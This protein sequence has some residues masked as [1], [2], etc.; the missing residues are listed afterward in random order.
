[1]SWR[2][3][4]K[5]HGQIYGLVNNIRNLY[6]IQI[7]QNQKALH[8]FVTLLL[9]IAILEKGWYSVVQIVKIL[10]M[11]KYKSIAAIF[12]GCIEEHKKIRYIDLHFACGR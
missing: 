8:F 3:H 2:Y 6:S 5:K 9:Y 7:F 11:D 10:P 12:S 1:M 4:F